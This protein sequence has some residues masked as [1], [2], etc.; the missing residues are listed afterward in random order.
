MWRGEKIELSEIKREY[1]PQYV[2]WFNDWEVSQF[3][4]PGIPAPM[5]IESETEWFENIRK[6]AN[7]YVF[8]ILTRDGSQL[9]GNCGLHDVDLKNRS[10]VFGIVIGDKNYWSQGYGTDATLTLLRFA[11]EQIG[12]NRVELF[13]YDFNP[14]AQRAYEKAGFKRSGVKRQGLF[15]NGAFHDEIMM[16][17]LREEWDKL[18]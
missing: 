18:K 11:F 6:R 2:A 5:S 8:A 10:A 16:D 17:I 15:R 9:I 12:L 4:M 14:R 7:N 3:L 1:L 13:V